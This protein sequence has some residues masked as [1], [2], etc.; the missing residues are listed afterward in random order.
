MQRKAAVLVFVAM[1]ATA[2]AVNPAH[3]QDSWWYAGGS[4]NYG[5][6]TTPRKQDSGWSGFFGYE[7]TP[8]YAVEASYSDLGSIRQSAPGF[9]SLVF[10]ATLVELGG[11]GAFEV[12]ERMSMYGKLGYYR[13]DTEFR[14]SLVGEPTEIQ[15]ESNS[16][17]TYAIGMR[18]NV[19]QNFAVRGSWQ[20]Y[21]K[22]GDATDIDVYAVGVMTKFGG[23]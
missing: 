15:S 16:N 2:L 21:R 3:A 17:Y 1:M 11:I 6:F 5:E 23:R 14:L 22:V 8:N 10:S 7:F 9:G 19:R 13:D 12:T 20:R 4:L 18:F